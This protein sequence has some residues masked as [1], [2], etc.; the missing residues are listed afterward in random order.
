[1]YALILDYQNYCSPTL[2]YCSSI[3]SSNKHS[4]H[5]QNIVDRLEN[6]QVKRYFTRKLL[7]LIYGYIHPLT[8]NIMV[9]V[10]I[11]LN[12]N[13]RRIKYFFLLIFKIMNQLTDI[14]IIRLSCKSSSRSNCIKLE[15]PFSQMQVL[16]TVATY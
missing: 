5:Y 7:F 11:C 8:I 2:E 1:M 16:L 3:C 9:I 15:Y 4:K 10:Q 12:Q 13:L 14:T 6:I